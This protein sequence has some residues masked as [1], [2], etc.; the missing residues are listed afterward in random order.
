M[1]LRKEVEKGI[2]IGSAYGWGAALG[3]IERVSAKAAGAMEFVGAI[4]GLIG[5]MIT[6]PGWNDLCEGIASGSGALLGL[7]LAAP[8]VA[9]RKIQGKGGLEAKG[10]IE[11]MLLKEGVAAQDMVAAGVGVRAAVGAGYLE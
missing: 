5:A 2:T 9:A 3:G 8:P 1:A 7:A 6:P 11:R 10:K 4:G